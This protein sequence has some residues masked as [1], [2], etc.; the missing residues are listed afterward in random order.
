MPRLPRPKGMVEAAIG[1][2]LGDLLE[3]SLEL[4]ARCSG[5]NQLREL[6]VPALVR[7]TDRHTL[8]DDLKPRMRCSIAACGTRNPTLF[9]RPKKR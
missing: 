4:H 1:A 8:L 5:C 3:G 6:D 7:S 2:T 9:I